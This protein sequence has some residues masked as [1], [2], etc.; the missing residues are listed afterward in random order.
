L[1]NLCMTKIRRYYIPNSIVFITAVT[2]NRDPLFLKKQNQEILESTI[3]N[4][5]NIHSFEVYAYVL[6]P[7]HAHWL[8]KIIDY[9][10]NFSKVLKCIK[11]NFTANFKKANNVSGQLSLWQPKFWDHVIRNEKDLGIHLDYIHWNPVKHGFVKNPENWENSS[12]QKW[13]S[14]GLYQSN[15]ASLKEPENIKGLDFE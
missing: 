12:F 15:W 10:D 11:G 2:K 13:V 14:F 3:N 8:L 5:M 1:Y 7:D 9:Q 4:A 6:L